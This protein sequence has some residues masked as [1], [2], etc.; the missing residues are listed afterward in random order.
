LFT[1]RS[2]P[3]SAGVLMAVLVAAALL[4]APA[5]SLAGEVE[6]ETCLGCH[7]DIGESFHLTAHG[8]YLSERPALAQYSCESCHG[9]GV[10]HIE[11]GDPALIINPAKSDQFG[12][13][14]C[15]TCHQDSR[16]DDWAFSHHNSADVN[17]ASC[18]Q[19]HSTNMQP[20]KKDTPEL[21]Y[22]CHS[23]IRQAAY[24]PSHHPV[25]EGKVSCL[26]CH[27]VHGGQA[28][29]TMD[30]T[31]RELCLSC[32]AD[33]EGP[34]VY[35][36]DP[37]MED[38]MICHTP[39]GSVADNLLKQNQPSLCLSCHPMHF[40]AV[41]EG[42]DGDFTVPLEPSRNGVSTTDGWKR[43]M[44]NKCTQCHTQVHGSDLPSQAASNGGAALTR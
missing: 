16:F 21:C 40:H 8:R 30:G 7:D 32:H 39:H 17:C 42:V 23:S 19:V 27:D 31:R 3:S 14:M 5:Y 37:V 43:V 2:G 13:Q 34:W 28:A 33:I 24:M 44:L 36:H 38:C 35:E 10:Q 4:M 12:A 1:N 26:D 25:A 22:D 6:N 9:S 20:T 11:G 15:M 18:H 29:L 41:S